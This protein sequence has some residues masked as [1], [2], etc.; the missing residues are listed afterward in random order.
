MEKLASEICHAF[1]I[2]SCAA[3]VYSSS[4]VIC[5]STMFASV[6]NFAEGRSLSEDRKE[7]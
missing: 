3:L 1:V 4:G 7:G 6:G 5:L 2:S